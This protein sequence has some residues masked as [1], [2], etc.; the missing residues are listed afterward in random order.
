VRQPH[1][2]SSPAWTTGGLI[3]ALSLSLSLLSTPTAFAQEAKAKAQTPPDT[4][5]LA[6]YVARD[7]L[8]LYMGCDGLDAHTDAW[9]KTAACRML[10]D[11]SLGAMLEDMT[12]QLADRALA[13]SPNRKLSGADVLAI[14]KHIAKHGFVFAVNLIKP[15]GDGSADVGVLVFKGAAAREVRT[16]FSRWIGTMMGEAKPQLVKK[17]SRSI[18]SVPPAPGGDAWSWWT[19]GN[20]LVLAAG[21]KAD[22]LVAAVLDGQ[23][24]SAVEHTIRTELAR[25]EGGFNPLG[26]FFMDPSAAPKAGAGPTVKTVQF[27]EQFGALGLNR[28][29]CRWGF[30]D[31]ALMTVTRLKA[32]K[33]RRAQLAVFDQPT[34]DK[35]QFPPMP[36][37]IESFAVLSVDSVKVLDYAIAMAKSPESKSK[38][39]DF[40]DNLKTKD[41]IDFRKDFL[42]HVG[43]KVAVYI[44]PGTT[45]ARSPSAAEKEAAAGA[46]AA[47]GGA[48]A[49]GVMGGMA[50]AAA[51]LGASGQ[52]PRLTLVAEV[53]DQGA[54]GKAL[55]GVMIALNRKLREQAA[56]DAEA[57]RTA[58]TAGE[59]GFPGGGAGAPGNR[60]RGRGGAGVG[61]G[62]GGEET[63]S[64]EGPPPALEFK[65]M[66]SKDKIYSLYIPP[67][68]SRQYPSGFRPTVRLSAKHVIFATTPDAARQATDVKPGAW[69]PGADLAATFDQ[70]PKDLTA[71]TIMDP[72]STAPELLASLP[73]NLQR[74]VNTAIAMNQAGGAGAAPGGGPGPG[75]PGP[76]GFAGPPGASGGGFRGRMAMP[77]GGPGP[78]GPGGD[79]PMPGASG[80]GFRG[81]MAM[82][83]GGPG[84]SGPGSS[85]GAGGP[86]AGMPGMPGMMPGNSGAMGGAPDASASPGMLTL[87]IDQAKLPKADELR[88]LMF[89]SSLAIATDDQEVRI[90]TRAAFPNV[91]SPTSALGIALA[92]PAI[93][94]ARQAAM[95]AAGVSAPAPAGGPP[96]G[97]ATGPGAAGAPP[98]GPAGAPS[99]IP[100]ERGA[101]GKGRRDGGPAA[102]V[103]R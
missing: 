79:A 43:P 48:P 82:P 5:P 57:A 42:A 64:R 27:F 97:A 8:V 101:R 98:A 58:A 102:A 66:P 26:I 95:K 69:T 67:S 88:N 40:V 12:T 33:P 36:E 24:P 13:S 10:N 100:A 47:P 81:R 70:L 16:P 61:G 9:K 76:E 14:I 68:L 3:L 22:E 87:N 39:T 56:A 94:A 73:A 50:G 17:G 53:N 89:P 60:P 1:S 103:P 52:V 34:F 21:K 30:Q 35:N 93:N 51:L 7:G 83:G 77:G 2:G 80:G 41:R 46:G 37:G 59:A 84:P 4:R 49:P 25:T 18:V 72:R 65:L 96:A 75:M 19:E 55:D 92:M 11:T 71:L 85:A 62:L 38:I 63:K 20:D 86:P 6:R 54:L 99:G 23:R 91:M 15:E 28:I 74:G 44:M 45:P 78:A 29:D 90:I 32:L 31:D